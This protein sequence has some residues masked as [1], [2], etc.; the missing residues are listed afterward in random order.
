MRARAEAERASARARATGALALTSVS[1]HDTPT[2]WR[3]SGQLVETPSQTSAVSHGF[4]AS[5]SRHG[6]PLG[7]GPLGKQIAELPAHTSSCVHSSCAPRVRHTMPATLKRHVLASQQRLRP[8]DD[9]EGGRLAQHC[10]H[11]L[12]TLAS[13]ATKVQSPDTSITHARIHARTHTTRTQLLP[14]VAVLASVN[15][16]VAARL[17]SAERR[18]QQKEH[19][20]ANHK[21]R[22]RDEIVVVGGR[23]R[24]LWSLFARAGACSVEK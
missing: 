13:S 1:G 15:T 11:K 24:T 16:T 18:T 10:T 5:A 4:A 19:A 9:G 22:W 21:H 6:V 7:E 12:A 14:A 20:Q 8:Y 17:S 2:G 3:R 23:A